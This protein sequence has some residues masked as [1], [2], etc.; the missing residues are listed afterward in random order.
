[1][2]LRGRN[3][4]E[5]WYNDEINIC[6]SLG[7]AHYDVKLSAINEPPVEEIRKVLE[8]FKSAPRPILIH[9]RYGADRTGLVAAMW[10]VAVDNESKAQAEKQFA[11]LYGH[12]PFGLTRAMDKYFERWNPP[13]K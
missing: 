5:Q 2:N 7:V 11:I 12:M 10:K 9:C 6:S 13:E 8:T 1:M 4:D 3:E